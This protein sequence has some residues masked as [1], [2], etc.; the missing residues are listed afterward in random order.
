[1]FK[2]TLLGAALTLASANALAIT[3]TTSNDAN[4]LVSQILG[5]GITISNAT[6]SGTDQSGGFTG[7][8]VFN[9][10]SGLVMTSGS[11]QTAADTVNN[12]DSTTINTAE[13]GDADLDALVAPFST[14]DAAV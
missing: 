9:M 3:V 6:Y 11:A 12:S 2:K 14:Q 8:T 10:G 13:P 5:G 4:T 7:D 1:M